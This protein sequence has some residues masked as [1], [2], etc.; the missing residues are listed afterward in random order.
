MARRDKT[1]LMAYLRV[2]E[3][4]DRNMLILLRRTSSR[5]D[6]QL[7]GLAGAQGV[8]AAVRRDQLVM[9]QRSIQG[10]ISRLWAAIGAQVKADR[11][12]A[13]TAAGEMMADYD[14]VLLRA[15]GPVDATALRRSAVAQATRGIET[16]E[17]R[18]LGLSRIPLSE[19]VYRSQALVTGRVE[20]I[21]EDALARGASAKEL[22]SD[23]SR[24]VKPTTP[25]GMR[26]AAMRLGRT[27][28]NNAFHAVQVQ[29]GVATPW[30]TG[31]RWNLSGSHPRPDECNDYE[32]A[33]V[34]AP[35]DVPPKPHPNCLCYLT[36]EPVPREVFIQ[37]YTAG[38]YDSYLAS[39]A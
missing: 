39:A 12:A 5:I 17:A 33:G 30:T 27:E 37:E 31:M 10:E 18:V 20:R 8:G 28:I 4:H 3:L 15:V 23:V 24:F 1:P 29:H 6:T 7:K 38:K 2:Q 13:A 19:K 21:I 16:V 22:A 32:E 25:G 34:Y 11:V 36:P 35:A 14:A 9:A 26:Y